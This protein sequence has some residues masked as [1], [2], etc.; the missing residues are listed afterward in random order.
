MAANISMEILTVAR[1]QAL[2]SVTRRPLQGTTNP[3]KTI[4]TEALASIPTNVVEYG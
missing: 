1:K 3:T 2:F 4:D